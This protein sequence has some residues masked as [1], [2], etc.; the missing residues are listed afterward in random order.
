[1]VEREQYADLTL[2]PR[3]GLLLILGRRERRI[4]KLLDCYRRAAG[5]A[6]IDGAIDSTEAAAPHNTL[7][8]I[9]PIQDSARR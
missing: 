3:D 8:S 6:Y 2:E 1:M 5:V 9:S 7:Y 4:K